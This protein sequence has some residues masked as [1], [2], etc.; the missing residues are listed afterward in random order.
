MTVL[1]QLRD[2]F[3]EHGAEDVLYYRSQMDV[4]NVFYHKKGID[5]RD[6]LRQDIDSVDREENIVCWQFEAVED[7]DTIERI[8]DISTQLIS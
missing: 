6:S 4:V 5:D 8:E 1:D 3:Q 7:E 2:V